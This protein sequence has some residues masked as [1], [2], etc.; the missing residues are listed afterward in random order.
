LLLVAVIGSVPLSGFV[1]RRL[2]SRPG[3]Q[4]IARPVSYAALLI[5]STAYL[6]DSSFNPFLY[7]RF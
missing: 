7:F 3:V 4:A 6:V 2:L 5:V 1:G